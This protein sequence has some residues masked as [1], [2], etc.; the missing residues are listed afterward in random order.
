MPRKNFNEL[1]AMLYE[2]LK[3]MLPSMVNKEVNNIAKM[4]VPIYVVEGL[5]LDRQETQADVAALIA[6]A[7]Q[8]EC[9]NLRAKLSLKIKFEKI[10]TTTPCRTY[11]I[12]PRDHED[13]QDNDSRPERESSVKRQKTSEYGTY[14]VGESLLEQPMDQEPHPSGS[15]TQTQLYEF[16]AWMDGFGTDDDEVL[17]E[18]AS[19]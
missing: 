13:H 17:T 19:Q 8:K 5:L 9:K 15:C 3:E 7:I 18:K 6:E 14:T 11:V 2:S 4:T 16:D 1:S 12:L 10:T